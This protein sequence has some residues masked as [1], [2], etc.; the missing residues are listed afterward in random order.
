MKF[1]APYLGPICYALSLISFVLAFLFRN[2][3][4]PTLI[5]LLACAF[6]CLWLGYIISK[7]AKEE[8]MYNF[9]PHNIQTE[10]SVYSMHLRLDN[11][12]II[13]YNGVPELKSATEL[14]IRQEN[15]KYYVY[16]NE[17]KLGYIPEDCNAYIL[18]KNCINDPSCILKAIIRKDGDRTFDI[19]CYQE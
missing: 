15:G 4:L 19:A 13:G 3:D 10:K 18:T 1:L 2:G 8:K 14:D 17:Q 9:F 11:T 16:S 12:A 6:G 7:Q 5:L